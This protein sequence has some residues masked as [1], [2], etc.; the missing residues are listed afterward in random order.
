MKA[1]ILA[2]GR[3][4]RMGALTND[5]PK[6]LLKVGAYHLI[7][8]QMMRLAAAGIVEFVIN[9]AYLGEQIAAALGD[10]SRYGVK[11][12]YSQEPEGGLETAGGIIAALPL[13]GEAPFVVANADVWCAPD[14]R[15][16]MS[17][18]I[19]D[20]HVDMLAQLL[21]VP[22]PAWKA[23]G[24]FDLAG[25]R[26]II[27]EQYTFAGISILHPRLFAGEQGGFLALAPFLRKAAQQG[28]VSGQVFTGQWQDVGTPERLYAL[29]AQYQ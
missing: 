5:C 20:Y 15:H 9:L 27:G 26:V 1:M 28:K 21:L 16:F 18:F 25:E 12:V 2:A 24:D 3:G 10:G 22:N 29:Q 4:K 23:V 19:K 17:R 8:W 6:P 14:E 7:E 13:L 11:I